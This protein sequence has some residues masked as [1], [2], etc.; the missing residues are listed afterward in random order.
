ML[1]GILL[2]AG[3]AAAQ[4]SN[5]T[6]VTQDIGKAP[7]VSFTLPPETALNVQKNNAL[8]YSEGWDMS[9]TLQLSSGNIYVHLLYPSTPINSRLSRAEIRTML[10]AF[11]PEMTGAGY[12]DTPLNISG[13][14]AV[15]GELQ[16]QSGNQTF[17]AYQPG[18]RTVAVVFFDQG[19]AQEV[20]SSFLKTLYI[21]T[22]EDASTQSAMPLIIAPEAVLP[23]ATESAAASSQVPLTTSESFSNPSSSHLDQ[24]MN[25]K[26]PGAE[27]RTE[28]LGLA[29]ERLDADREAA[30]E[31]LGQAKENLGP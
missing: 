31:R 16:L 19:L 26:G 4:N 14:S 18:I 3:C 6:S 25:D 11:R 28:R 22:N 2:A 9:T 20:Q 12:Y 13:K 30:Y 7:S 24:I 29:L 5:Y 17:V 10:E 15:S 27:A 21:Q 8:S 23:Q 1:C